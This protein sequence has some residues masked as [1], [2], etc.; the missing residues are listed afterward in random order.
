MVEYRSWII[1]DL[2]IFGVEDYFHYL[3]CV[4]HHAAGVW[5]LIPIGIFCYVLTKNELNLIE[6]K[7][8]CFEIT[9]ILYLFYKEDH[10]KDHICWYE[11]FFFGPL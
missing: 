4:G 2:A 1:C 11:I 3:A 8:I 7:N 6:D 10:N 5:G 9:F